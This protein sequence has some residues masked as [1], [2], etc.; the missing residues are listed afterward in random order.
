MLLA[1]TGYRLEQAGP[2]LALVARQPGLVP[3]PQQ[4]LAVDRRLRPAGLTEPT[5]YRPEL[6]LGLSLRLLRSCLGLCGNLS[7]GLLWTGGYDLR[8]SLCRL[9]TGLSWLSLSLRLLRG[10]LGLCRNLSSGLLWSGGYDL[11]GLL[12]RL[13]TGRGRL[14]LSLCLLGC[15]DWVPVEAG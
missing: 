12:C 9:G 7:S 11:R 5:G 13:G 2:E 3:Q 8:G 1:P 14:S 4:R 6:W 10:S 15:A